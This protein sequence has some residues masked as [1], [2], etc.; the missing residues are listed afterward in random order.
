MGRTAGVDGYS[1]DGDRETHGEVAQVQ[2]KQGK[3]VG[4]GGITSRAQMYVFFSSLFLFLTVLLGHDDD[5]E[6]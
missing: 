3:K 2:G 1:N 5:D 4:S 6:R